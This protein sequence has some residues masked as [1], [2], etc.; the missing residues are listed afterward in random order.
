MSLWILFAAIVAPAVFWIG[1]YYYKD[2]F[3]REPVANLVEAFALGF[4]AG[5]LCWAFYSLLSR[6]GFQV[7][8]QAAYLARSRLDFL[9]YCVGTIG[10]LEEAFKFLPFLMILRRIKAFDEKID[11]I[12]YASALA[13]GFASFE[14]LG[15]LTDMKGWALV[16]RA[17]ASPLTHAVF[18]SIWGYAVGRATILGR[19]V[20]RASLYG[21]LLGGLVHGLFDFL[22]VSPVRRLLS[23]VLILLVWVWQLRLLEKERA[24]K[25]CAERTTP[26]A[27][28]DD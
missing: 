3:R 10:I 27:E 14:N 4:L 7:D 5:F 22:T 2:C 28:R 8:F 21:L 16:G 13:V 15:Y 9:L 18:A 1:Y 11:G 26:A 20:A 17:F 23:A 6:L 19:S 12:I 25:G 24:K